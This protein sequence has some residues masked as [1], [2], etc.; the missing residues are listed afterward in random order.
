MEILSHVDSMFVL[1]SFGSIQVAELDW[2]NADHIKAVAPPFDYIIGT[3]VVSFPDAYILQKN[4][5]GVLILIHVESDNYLHYC[6]NSILM[7]VRCR[8]FYC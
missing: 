8:N 4:V 1:D 7:L 6:R 5:P 2:G 3:D